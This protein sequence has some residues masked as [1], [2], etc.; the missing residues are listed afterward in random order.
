MNRVIFV[1]TGN[2]CRSPMAEG[3]L[4]ARLA[5]HDIKDIVVSSMGV[6]GLD[7]KPASELAQKVCA[8]NGIDI[9]GHVSRQ[10]DF[11]EINESKLILTLEM[12]HKDFMLLFFK[13]LADRVF[14]L[15][16]WPGE[17]SPKG[18]VRDPMGGTIKDYRKAFETIARHIDRILPDL[19]HMFG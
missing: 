8:E 5:A 10:L 4:K 9:S 17:D 19:R 18:D 11:D 3:I 15:G 16:C 1:C 7:H 2:V 6:H 14:S 13:H 12:A